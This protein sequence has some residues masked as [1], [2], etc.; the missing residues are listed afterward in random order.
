MVET[1]ARV[2]MAGSVGGTV[3]AMHSAAAVVMGEMGAR[4][5]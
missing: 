3:S 5:S 2:V 1:V 4:V